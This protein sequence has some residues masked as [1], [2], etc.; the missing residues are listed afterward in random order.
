[1]TC[2]TAKDNFAVTAIPVYPG[3][4]TGL[5]DRSRFKVRHLVLA[6]GQAIG[7][8]THLHRAK[9]LVVVCGAAR[10]IL[11]ETALALYETRSAD[12][13][14]GTTHRIENPGRVDLHLIE[15]QTGAY[16]GEDD[17]LA[18]TGQMA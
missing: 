6:P 8:F 12:I 5:P 1:M 7:P 9:H 3:L 11:N 4:D 10:L 17:V 13:P 18:E 15:V 14:I 16:L 2:H